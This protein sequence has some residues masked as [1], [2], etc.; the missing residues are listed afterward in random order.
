MNLAPYKQ[1]NNWVGISDFLPSRN[2]EEK[3]RKYQPGTTGGSGTQ[4]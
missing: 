2:S 3:N 4:K 1:G